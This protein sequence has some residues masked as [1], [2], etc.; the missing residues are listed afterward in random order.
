MR[1]TDVSLQSIE[2]IKFYVREHACR[3]ARTKVFASSQDH[4]LAVAC[5]AGIRRAART[6]KRDIGIGGSAR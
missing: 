4:L 2:T 6:D 1:E 3:E 5:S